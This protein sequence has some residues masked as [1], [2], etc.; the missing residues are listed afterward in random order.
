MRNDIITCVAFCSAGRPL[1]DVAGAALAH[2]RIG[3]WQRRRRR[4]GSARRVPER[5]VMKGS[6]D[7]SAVRCVTYCCK[8]M[9]VGSEQY[10][11]AAAADDDDDDDDDAIELG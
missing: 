10:T 4:H 6:G 8:G 9:G 2:R 7:E 5:K 11:A 3:S 1:H